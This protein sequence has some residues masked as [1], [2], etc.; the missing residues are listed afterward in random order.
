MAAGNWQSGA[1][2]GDSNTALVAKSMEIALHES[3]KNRGIIASPVMRRILARDQGLGNLLGT[4]GLQFT[5]LDLGQGKMTATAEGS[6]VALTNI[7]DGTP[8]TLTPARRAKAIALSDWA[9]TLNDALLQGVLAPSAIA[10]LVFDGLRSWENDLVDRIAALATSATYSG[11]TTGQD[12]TWQALQDVTYDMTDRGASGDAIALLKVKGVKDLAGD[13]LSLGGAV[14]MAGQ[15]QQFL[16]NAGKTGYIGRFFNGVDL[17]MCSELDTSGAD[18]VG[19]IFNEDG[20]HTKHQQVPLPAEADSVANAG[21][22]TVEATRS[23]G[24]MSRVE[25]VTYNAVGI[26]QQPGLAKLLYSTT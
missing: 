23:G 8:V 9:R 22:F 2:P 15:V 17:Y 10:A 21:L 6:A 7:D 5:F 3:S 24:S 18:D 14:Q 12:F 20:I 13:A 19:I 4:L 16:N 11:G 26:R 1:G 25:T